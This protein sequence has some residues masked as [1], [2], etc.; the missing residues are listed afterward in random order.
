MGQV[1][2]LLGQP[3]HHKEAANRHISKSPVEIP[4]PIPQLTQRFLAVELV[5][6]TTA[7]PAQPAPQGQTPGVMPGSRSTP[8]IGLLR[9]GHAPP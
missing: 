4:H 6:V 2:K 5:S 8:C 3:V 7:S 9:W 1:G